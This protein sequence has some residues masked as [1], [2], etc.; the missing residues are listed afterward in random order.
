MRRNFSESSRIRDSSASR[1]RRRMGSHSAAPRIEEVVPPFCLAIASVLDLNPGRR[2]GVVRTAG[3]LRNDA[4]KIVRAGGTEQVDAP[5]RHL[6]YVQEGGGFE[7]HDPAQQALAL[8]QRQI[9]QIAAAK[10][11]Q[12]ESVEMLR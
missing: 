5:A 4:F 10:P 12:I 7:R 11:K 1:S 9:P 8:E 2:I 3:E 6:V